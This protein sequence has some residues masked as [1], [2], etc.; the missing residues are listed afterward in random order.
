MERGGGGS[1]LGVEERE[2]LVRVLTQVRVSL[3]CVRESGWCTCM[4]VCVCALHKR[5]GLART[6]CVLYMVVYMVV[7]LPNTP[8]IHRIYMVLANPTKDDY[9][10]S[11]KQ[12]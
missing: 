9:R 12:T 11:S 3:V 4:Y 5:L 8:Y 2:E 10:A 6:V 7:S 1:A